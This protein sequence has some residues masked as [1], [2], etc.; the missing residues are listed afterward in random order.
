MD[1]L[2]L[3]QYRKIIALV[4]TGAVIF[5]LNRLGMDL[6]DLSPWGL[7]LGSIAEPIVEFIVLFG[8]PAVM[9]LAQPNEKGR[10]ILA[11]WRWVVAGAAVLAVMIGFV[12]AVF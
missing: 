9:T 12:I 4:V 7:S 1:D 3:S 6:R 2:N 5:T 11:Y 10:S 8:I